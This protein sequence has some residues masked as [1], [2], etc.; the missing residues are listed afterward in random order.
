MPQLKTLDISYNEFTVIPSIIGKR[1]P[2]LETLVL[3]HNPIEVLEFKETLKIQR[4]SMSNMPKISSV[5]FSNFSRLQ[6]SL[7]GSNGSCLEL[8]I[9]HCPLLTNVYTTHAFEFQLCKLDLSYNKIERIQQNFTEWTNI[10]NGINLQGNPFICNCE[11]QWMLDIILNYIYA[12]RELQY[13]LLDLRCA[14]PAPFEG[15]RFVRYYKR[16]KS[17]C[18]P[19]EKIQMAGFG[20]SNEEGFRG[21]NLKGRPHYLTIIVGCIVLLLAMI[22]LGLHWQKQINKTLSKHNRR[23]DHNIF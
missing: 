10:P 14:E 23:Y 17:F 2:L 4:I 8:T 21:I 6:G 7:K 20:S 13:L 12:R 9:S 15:K 19:N 3:D 5:D 16:Y 11:D 18:Y 22:M 1:S